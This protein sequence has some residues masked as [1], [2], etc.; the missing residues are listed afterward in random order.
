MQRRRLFGRTALQ[1][2]RPDADREREIER[3]QAEVFQ[4]RR[5][6]QGTREYGPWIIA[7][8]WGVPLFLLLLS[9]GEVEAGFNPRTLTFLSLSAALVA[10]PV[11]GHRVAR[12][13]TL[14]HRRMLRARLQRRTAAEPDTLVLTAYLGLEGVS[15]ED[16]QE[17]IRPLVARLQARITE[18]VPS[19]T[20]TFR[21][22]EVTASGG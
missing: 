17:L 2:R 5:S 15:G 7:W 6:L 20:P 12:W 9:L 13:A 3:L 10:A 22:D 11:V 16:T 1:E 8:L 19:P 18:V 14:A 4:A 21:G